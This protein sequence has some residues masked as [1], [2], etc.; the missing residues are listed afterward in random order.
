VD[1]TVQN[2]AVAAARQSVSPN[3]P[4]LHIVPAT[5][6]LVIEARVANEDIGYI[7]PGQPATIKVRAYDFVR[8]GSIEGKLEKIGADAVED[9][10]TGAMTFPVAIGAERAWLEENGKR[11]AIAPGMQVEA[12]LH[13]GRRTLLSYLTDRMHRASEN[14]FRER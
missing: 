6:R 2:L 4:I 7:R 10:R 9:P 13:I 8:F 14:A 12:D 1:G 3:E 5:E 11:H